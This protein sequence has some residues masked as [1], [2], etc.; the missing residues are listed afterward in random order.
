MVW[1]AGDGVDNVDG[2]SGAGDVLRVTLTNGDDAAQYSRWGQGFSVQV[3]GVVAL[4][5]VKVEA[6]DLFALRGLD[7]ITVNPLGNSPLASIRSFLGDDDAADSVVVNGSTGD[8][9]FVMSV[10]ANTVTINPKP[11]VAITV[12]DA[13]SAKGSASFILNLGDGNDSLLVNQTLAGSNT[14]VNAGTGDDI[15][16]VRTINGATTIN[17]GIGSD[18][19]NVGS[20]AQ[21]D[22]QSPAANSAGNVNGIAAL[23]TVN[24]DAA[25]G[26]GD[27]MNVDETGDAAVNTGALTSTLLTG[28]GMGGGIAYG[29]LET[30]NISLGTGF[31]SFNVRS[32]AGIT[33]TTLNSGKATSEV[34]QVSNTPN[35]TITTSTP[36][37]LAPGQLISISGVGGALGVNGNY[38]VLALDPAH[39]TTRSGSQCHQRGQSDARR[40]RNR[41]WSARV[42]RHP[43]IGRRHSQCR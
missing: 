1:S 6:S 8:D 4:T 40:V 22:A 19:I 13:Q 9:S 26:G 42:P 27:A 43:R 3:G 33:T 18:V 14:L 38:T 29:T 23:L 12:E 32:T 15:I 5:V 16:N 17:G 39:P 25:V 7:T 35:P 20:R 11:G 36:H 21:G 2:G 37:G 10:V 31:N 41:R 34:T 24:G 30:L 28:L